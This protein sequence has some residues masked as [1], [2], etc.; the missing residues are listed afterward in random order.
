MARNL[1]ISG[2]FMKKKS[3][4]VAVAACLAAVL[5]G[6]LTGCFIRQDNFLKSYGETAF[7][8]TPYSLITL[9]EAERAEAFAENFVVVP[10]SL[11]NLDSDITSV[12]ASL[13]CLDDNTALYAKNVHQSMNPAS[14]TKLM[15]AYLAVKYGNLDDIVT[16]TDASAI[17]EKGAS[18][19]GLNT[20]DK[21][22][23]RDLLYCSLIYSGNDAAAAIA[24]HISGSQEAFAGLM[25]KEATLL[26]ATNT[27]FKN[28]HGLT[29]EGHLTTAYDIYLIMKEAI[30]NDIILDCIKQ[31]AYTY[32]YMGADGKEIT[33]TFNSTNKYFA[34]QYA[35]PAGITVIGGKTGTTIAAGNCLALLTQDTSTGKFY[36]SIILKASN[37][38]NL[39]G[40]MSKLLELR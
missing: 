35:V 15:T 36:I 29:E 2:V 6:S 32:T 37:V 13:Y 16:I 14:L 4:A 38:D 11:N 24:V 27:T 5:A 12:S 28:P 19:I 34:K 21:I 10:D 33:K 3:F 40:E 20:G 23:L 30:K 7:S 8:Y 1:Q 9:S 17:T 25:T 31:T 26:G 22:S 39:Y 18:K